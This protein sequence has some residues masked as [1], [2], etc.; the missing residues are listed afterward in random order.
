MDLDYNTF[1]EMAERAVENYENDVAA[2]QGALAHWLRISLSVRKW[3]KRYP[4]DGL[5]HTDVLE[6]I[7][8][9]E[10]P[11]SVA[12]YDKNV[13]NLAMDLLYSLHNDEFELYRVAKHFLD[14]EEVYESY[15]LDPEFYNWMVLRQDV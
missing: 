7:E 15:T 1:K 4:F 3:W 12:K 8:R 2:R 5:T 14:N 10:I 6:W 11:T 9:L 13:Y